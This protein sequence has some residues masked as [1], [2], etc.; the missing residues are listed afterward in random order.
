ML[1]GLK[2]KDAKSDRKVAAAIRYDEKKDQAPKITAK[3][4]GRVA[5]KIIE[6]A[7]AANVPLRED[8]DLAHALAQLPIGED[9]PPNLYKAVAEVLAFLYKLNSRE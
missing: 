8:P 7:I 2:E 3:G 4:F 9:I 6:K 5:E 1:E